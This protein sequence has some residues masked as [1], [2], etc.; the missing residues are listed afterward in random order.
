M[1][2]LLT[3]LEWYLAVGMAVATVGLLKQL[4]TH[5]ELFGPVEIITIVLL[6]P[7]LLWYVYRK[8]G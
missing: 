8:E 2:T 1:Q 3:V 6:Y 5:R 7:W 4:W